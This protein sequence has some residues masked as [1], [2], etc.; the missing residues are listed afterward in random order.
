VLEAKTDSR[1]EKGEWIMAIIPLYYVVADTYPVDSTTVDIAEGQCVAL[2]SAGV[3]RCDGTGGVQK[4][5]GLAGDTKAVSNMY[6]TMPG[7]ST[8]WQNRVS[9]GYDETKASGMLTVYHSGGV[10]ATDMFVNSNVAAANVG[11]Y[12]KADA[13]TGNLTWDS[14]TKSLVSIAQLVAPAGAYPSGVPGTD[15]TPPPFDNVGDAALAGITANG[16]IVVKLLI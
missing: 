16:F 11:D 6:S 14:A 1:N 10:F 3:R 9:D 4:V 7:V 12:F 8:G 15:F 2:T 13:S 5:I